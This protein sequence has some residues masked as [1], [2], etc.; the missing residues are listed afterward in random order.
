[1]KVIEKAVMSN[2]IKIKLED[3]SENN[4]KEF[5]DLYGLA[6]AAYPIAKNTGKYRGIKG[7]DNFRLS[8][9]SNKYQNYTDD[10]VKADFEALKNGEKSLE[11][12]A[13]HFWN[14]EKDMWYLGLNVE[15]K[16][17]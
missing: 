16:G 2:G 7:G 14:G 8:I 10:N 6:I 9:H 12:L 13:D 1:M 3:W 4:T 5:P 17:W 11:E 15:Y